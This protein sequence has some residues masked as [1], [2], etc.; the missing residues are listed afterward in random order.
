MDWTHIAEGCGLRRLYSKCV[1]EIAATLARARKGVG[2]RTMSSQNLLADLPMGP[3]ASADGLHT[4]LSDMALLEV[5]SSGRVE[6]AV[7]RRRTVHAAHARS[8]VS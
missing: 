8:R 3:S 2:P 1:R 4:A 7:G 6:C 5:G